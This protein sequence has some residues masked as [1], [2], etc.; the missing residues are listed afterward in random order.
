MFK[1]ISLVAVITVIFALVFTSS[2]LAAKSKYTFEDVIIGNQTVEIEAS[3][4]QN[5]NGAYSTCSYFKQNYV[6]HLGLYDDAVVAGD[7]EEAVL[8]FCVDNFENR[9]P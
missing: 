6:E 3:V 7:D 1:K 4:K 5:K 2:V 9:S 8:T